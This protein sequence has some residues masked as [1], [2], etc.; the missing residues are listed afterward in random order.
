MTSLAV[1]G[2]IGMAATTTVEAITTVAA[3]FTEADTPEVDMLTGVAQATIAF[4]AKP[5]TTESK[6]LGFGRGAFLCPEGA[7]SFKTCP[8]EAC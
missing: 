1:T 3:M 7:A 2:S 8:L 6:L 4:E 5:L